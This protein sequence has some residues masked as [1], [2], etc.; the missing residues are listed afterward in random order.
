MRALIT[1]GLLTRITA[2]ILSGMMAVGYFVAH[3][4]RDFYPIN[5]GGELAILFCFIFLYIAAAGP[6]PWSVDA[7]RGGPPSAAQQRAPVERQ[8]L[9]QLLGRKPPAP[10]TLCAS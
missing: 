5:N 4:P 7:I 9:S 1:L 3:A 8:G 10:K 2:L 6:G